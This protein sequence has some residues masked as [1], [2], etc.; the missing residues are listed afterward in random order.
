MVGKEDWT[1]EEKQ[2]PK[3]AARAPEPTLPNAGYS[4][5]NT[6][7]QSIIVAGGIAAGGGSVAGSSSSVATG[8]TGYSKAT[9]NAYV[10]SWKNGKG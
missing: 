9:S 4:R 5:Q 1:A 7:L 8:M 6:G 10:P 3:I 2:L